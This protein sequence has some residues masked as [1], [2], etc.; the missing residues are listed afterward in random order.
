VRQ[1]RRS[2]GAS[3]NDGRVKPGEMIQ[4]LE[5]CRGVQ[6]ATRYATILKAQI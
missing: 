3:W 2:V 5:G 4:L 1:L 6:L